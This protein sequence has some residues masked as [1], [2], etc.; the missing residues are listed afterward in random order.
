MEDLIGFVSEK[1]RLPLPT[2]KMVATATL[3]YLTP[4]F[5]PLLKS[6]VEVLLHYPNLSGAEKDLLIASRVLFPTD[7]TP[8]NKPLQRND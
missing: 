6:S 2:A 1:A 7:T 8:M 5:S 3:D 4:H